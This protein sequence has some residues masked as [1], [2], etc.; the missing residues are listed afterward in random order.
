MSGINPE[1][2]LATIA[3]DHPPGPDV[4]E[5]ISG[6]VAPVRV[7]WYERAFYDG[8][9]RHYWD[10]VGW[11]AR[12]D[13][14]PHWRQVDAYPCWRGL[15]VEAIASGGLASDA[16]EVFARFFNCIP[17]EVLKNEVPAP[18]QKLV[19]EVMQ[20]R[21]YR[22]VFNSWY[23]QEPPTLP[24]DEE[25]RAIWRAAGGTFHGPHVE[26]GS[27]SESKLL[28]FLRSLGAQS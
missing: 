22:M 24:T 20:K 9:F 3:R 26:T 12:Q 28:P 18:L 6:R 25:L 17:I 14:S 11:L 10:G 21:G 5:W 4:T 15:S 8:I 2:W 19:G 13:G 27:M 7:G 23:L 16:F 1:A